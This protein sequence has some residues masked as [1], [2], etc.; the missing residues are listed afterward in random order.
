MLNSIEDYLYTTPV[1]LSVYLVAVCYHLHLF[2]QLPSC[3]MVPT[4]LL[5]SSFNSTCLLSSAMIYSVLYKLKNMFL[6][7]KQLT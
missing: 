1:I 6:A 4:V 7:Q 5:S 2:L 3:N